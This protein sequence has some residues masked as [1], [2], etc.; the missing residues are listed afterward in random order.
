MDKDIEER[1]TQ[2]ENMV[3]E[4]IGVAVGIKKLIEGR[5][6]S[7]Y[8]RIGEKNPPSESSIPQRKNRIDTKTGSSST[9]DPT[10]TGSNS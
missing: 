6:T 8:E 1:A 7:Y 2:L 9:N 4:L 10:G 5:L 3:D